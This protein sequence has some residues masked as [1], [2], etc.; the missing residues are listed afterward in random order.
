M[1]SLF[2][3][4]IIAG[5]S[6][7]FYLKSTLIKSF[8]SV[9]IAI[10]SVTASFNYFEVLADVLIKRVGAGFIANW[11]QAVSFLLITILS[12][13][14]LQTIFAKLTEKPLDFGVIPERIV[15]IVCGFFVGLIA[16]GLLLTVVMLSPL[17]NKYPYQRF[18]PMA[19]DA[20][21][22]NKILLNPDGF[23]SSMFSSLSQGVFRSI[24]E[25]KSF[26]A[27]H[28][29]FQDQIF[30]NRHVEEQG[31]SLLTSAAAIEV[32]RKDAAWFASEDLVDSEN[33]AV[34]SKSG[35]SL[36]VVRVG[37]RKKLLKEVGKFTTSQLRLVC[38]DK[39]AGADPFASAA[40]AV[41]PLGYLV[42]SNQLQRKR[43][44]DLIELSLEDFAGSVKWI[45]FVFDVPDNSVPMLIEFKLNNIAKLPGRISSEPPEAVQ[46]IPTSE[47]T[48]DIAEVEPVSSDQI[49]GSELASGNNFLEG[50]D[51]E[52]QSVNHW[53]VSETEDSIEPGQFDGGK[54]NYVRAEMEIVEAPEKETR[55]QRIKRRRLY[56]KPGSKIGGGMG[57]TAAMLMPLDGYKL[58][59]LKCKNPP[60]GSELSGE[61][62][63]V[64]IELGGGKHHAIGVIAKGTMENESE[65]IYEVDFCSLSSEEITGGLVIDNDGKVAKAFPPKIWLTKKAREIEQFYVLYLIKSGRKTI[66]TGVQPFGS[67]VTAGFEKYE[68]FLI[69]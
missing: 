41:Y 9:I 58:V 26:A 25:K 34:T 14:I 57:S 6:V 24:R 10:C 11:S 27:L 46:F 59:S 67:N 43:L 8:G 40:K 19:P 60:V 65:V 1:A 66:I 37:I 49:S 63:P 55:A 50:F 39:N 51:L 7:Y 45:D 48:Q 15:R 21:K 35:H 3:I 30:L 52:I 47:C 2:V 22:P 16:T 42:R 18:A 64:L 32:L 53:Q 20:Q 62:L 13:A 5:C 36:T 12:F 31:L 23:V 56:R 28:P 61:Q 17:S 38:T 69:K 44:N 29:G 54:L 4:L 33:Q 68:G